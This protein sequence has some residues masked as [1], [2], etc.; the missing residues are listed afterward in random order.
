MAESSTMA[1]RIAFGAKDRIEAA[2]E[3]DMIDS[4]D[5][6][7]LSNQEMGWID[8][9]GNPVISKSRT[10]EAIKVN[11]VTA[12][13]VED[14]YEIPAG[15]SLDEIIKMLVQ[16]AVP[17]TYTK[18]SLTFTSTAA[19][20]YEVG[21]IVSDTFTAK[22]TQNDSQGLNELRIKNNAG[23]VVANTTDASLTTDPQE[24]QVVYGTIKY[25]AE[26]DYQASI[27]KQDNLGN[28]SLDNA[29]VAGTLT[30]SKS[31]VGKWNAF[32]GTGSGELPEVVSGNVRAL[33]GKLLGPGAGSSFNISLP[34]GDQ[35]VMFAYP[36]SLRDVNQVMYVETNDTGMAANFD[37]TLVS[38]EGAN[39][40][41]GCEYKVYT[42]QMATPA[43]AGMT[44]KVTI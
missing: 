43:D 21:T 37:K 34:A 8:A 29:F 17:A 31:Y 3:A 39:G 18:P 11:G 14:G 25:T 30:S 20:N 6:L 41:T 27:T 40:V 4:Y 7:C 44:F 1:T 12:L 26:A 38:V 9:E 23:T 19:G 24:I 28:D 32:Y 22:F 10:Q 2:L 42:Y 15:K 5:I 16:K 35:W 13:G 33:N 36:S